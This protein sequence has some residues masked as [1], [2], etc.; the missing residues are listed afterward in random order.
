[1]T[2][3]GAFWILVQVGAGS[4]VNDR[5]VPVGRSF[6]VLGVLPVRAPVFFGLL[7]IVCFEPLDQL[8]V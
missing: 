6:S 7:V 3:A 5:D 8:K 4:F 2:V 1:M